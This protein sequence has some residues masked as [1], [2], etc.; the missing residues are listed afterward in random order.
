VVYLPG[1]VLVTT[2]SFVG[3]A[4]AWRNS[5]GPRRRRFRARPFPPEWVEILQSNVALY[6]KLPEPLRKQ[7]HSH[8]QVF[9]AEKSFEGCGGLELT[10]E[11]RVTI[12]GLACILLLNREARYYPG[13]TAIL[14]YPAAYIVSA[15]RREGF[16]EFADQREVR[17]G[18]SWSNGTL[19]L[20]WCDVTSTSH[21]VRDGHNLVLHE[22]A[23]QLDQEDGTGNGIPIIEQRSKY[24]HWAEVL[25]K[26]YQHLVEVTRKGKK[27]VLQAYGAT[28][29][30]EF[31][32]VSTEA[33]FEKPAQLHRKHA[34][35]Y[36]ELKDFFKLDPETWAEPV[37]V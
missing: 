6:R 9:L 8:I 5:P 3:G 30:A 20:A 27:D 28:N 11:M 13:L 31:F 12:A 10:D 34:E 4:L 1:V 21:D 36:E 24:Y 32:A 35:L 23:H 7:L 17:L 26:E 14:V 18:E 2:V 29:P 22:F 37:K 16:V 19:V 33:F 15:K 25:S